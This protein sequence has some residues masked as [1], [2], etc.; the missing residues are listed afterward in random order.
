MTTSATIL[1]ATRQAMAGLGP[2]RLTMSG[3]ARAAG[4]SRP[5]LYRWFPTKA[6]LLAALANHE[7]EQFTAGL[8][9][10]ID[11]H[12]APA[13]R[14]D[15]ALRYL[16]TFLESSSIPDPIGADPA[17]ALRSLAEGMPRQIAAFSDLLGDALDVIP[18]VGAG[19]LSR[20][21]ATELLLRLA[22]SHFLIPHADSEALLRAVRGLAGV[23]AL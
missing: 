7:E 5:T 11:R 4:V 15:A 23:R 17:F 12:P 9:Q 8:I 20:P 16:V 18:A 1:E 13:E 21:E 6:D 19:E 10:V 22:Y 2:E 3:V 14:L